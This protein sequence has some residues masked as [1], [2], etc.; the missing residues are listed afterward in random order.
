[1][2]RHA[3]VARVREMPEVESPLRMLA[4]LQ[5]DLEK[6]KSQQHKHEHSKLTS[7]VLSGIHFRAS[8]FASGKELELT[9]MRL[10]RTIKNPDAI[11]LSEQLAGDPSD[12]E[13]RLNL[14]GLYLE[15]AEKADL[16]CAR[17]DY[18]LAVLDLQSPFLSFNKINSALTTQLFYLKR[19][20]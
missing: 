7:S 16:I 3:S 2:T 13:T 4:A 9:G 18:L 20:F 12:S 17:D 19:L 15:V 1:M 10:S 11:R 6:L 5:S 14:I 8:D